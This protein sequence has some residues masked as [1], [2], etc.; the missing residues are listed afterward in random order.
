MLTPLPPSP[1]PLAG[2]DPPPAGLTFDPD[3]PLA[4]PDI[5]PCGQTDRH[6]SKHNL[7]VVLRTR[8][9]IN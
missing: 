9:V 2:P 8:A 6:V 7:P 5:P 1:P 4:G 3:P